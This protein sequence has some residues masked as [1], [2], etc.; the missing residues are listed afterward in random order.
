[1]RDVDWEERIVIRVMKDRDMKATFCD[2]VEAKGR[3]VDGTIERVIESIGRLGY[4]NVIVKP[5]QEPALV[6]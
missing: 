1:M 3:G 6:D 4:H 2:V 5:K